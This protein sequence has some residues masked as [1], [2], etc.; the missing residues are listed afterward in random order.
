MKRTAATLLALLC[1]SSFFGCVGPSSDKGAGG[2]GDNGSSGGLPPAEADYKEALENFD[3]DYSFNQPG[4]QLGY[5]YLI[6]GRDIKNE[7][8]ERSYHTY[9]TQCLSPDDGYYLAYIRTQTIDECVDKLKEIEDKRGSS[10]DYH[11]TSAQNS[12]VI[13][14]KYFYALQSLEKDLSAEVKYKTASRLSDIEYIYGEHTLVFCARSKSAVIQSDLTSGEQINRM[15]KLFMRCELAYD[16][17]GF[18]PYTFEGEEGANQQYSQSVFD[19][20]GIKI[21]A[22]GS[23][24]AEADY[25]SIPAMGMARRGVYAEV[26]EA[27]GK[28][29]VELPRYTTSGT[30]LLADGVSVIDDIY[31]SAK[32][33]FREA[34]IKEG[35]RAS[36]YVFGLFEYDKVKTILKSIV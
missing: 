8:G 2:E 29:C 18:T 6:F 13:D 7:E 17:E 21:G 14:G 26:K 12:S 32:S 36:G 9:Q 5:D 34:Y 25:L 22:F 11:F 15:V 28:T 30:D 23:R 19:Y 35:K 20:V 31:G 1:L 3:F 24:Y 4:A 16:G 33:S 27:N 10:P